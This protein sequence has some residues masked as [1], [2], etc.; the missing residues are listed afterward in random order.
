MA[1]ERQGQV[2]EAIRAAARPSN[3]TRRVRT[4]TSSACAC[5]PG[6]S[7]TRRWPSTAAPS[8]STRGA[9]AHYQL[10]MCLQARGR[11]DEAMAEFRRAIELDPKGAPAHHQLGMCWQAKGQ[12]DEA[13]AEY[14]RAIELDPKGGAGP[15]PARH[16]LAGQGPARR[17]DGRVP[18]R[19]RARPQGGPGPLPARHVLAGQGPARRGDGRIPPRHR[20]RPQVR[21]RPTTSSARV[22]QD[23]GQLDEAMAEYRRAIDLDPGGGMAHESLAEALLR[24]GRFAEARTAVRRGLDLLPAEE[25][26]RPALREKL[27]LCERMLALDARLPALLQGKERPAAAEQLELAR[28]CRDYGRPHAAAGLYAAAFAARPELADDLGSGDR[29][30]AACAAARAADDGPRRGAARRAGARRPAPAGA[31][32]VAGRP[33]PEGQAAARRQIAVRRRSRPGR[34]T[35]TWRASG[36]R[37]HWRS[38]PPPSA[39][40]GGASGRTWRRRSPPIPLEQGRASAARRDWARAADCYAKAIEGRPDRR[41]P[42]LVRV[43][44][45]VAAVRRSPG[46]RQG[47]RPHD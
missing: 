11:L 9:Q 37:R 2:D 31:G 24:S 36:T 43:R 10:G 46:L 29:Y 47:L 30:N 44:R 39:R 38:C 7:S 13:M 5:R 15:P 18:P 16:V 42:L 23:R 25:P 21:P 3:S 28:L 40:S 45:P 6:A 8:N 4:T 34:R 32:L 1:L 41:R 14:R 12:L 26:R 35:P 17:G 33:G 20:A 27:E 22:W 19:H